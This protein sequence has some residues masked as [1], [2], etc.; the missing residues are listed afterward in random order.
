MGLSGFHLNVQK[1]AL[2][3]LTP[4]ANVVILKDSGLRPV[5]PQGSHG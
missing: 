2:P 5:I 1:L 4:D 3:V